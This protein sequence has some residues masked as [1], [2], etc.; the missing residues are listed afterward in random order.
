MVKTA[1]DYEA[2]PCALRYPRGEVVGV[3]L[4]DQ[5]VAIPIGCGE[6]VGADAGELDVLFLGAGLAVQSALHARQIVRTQ[7]WRTGLINAR[8][9]KP[10]DTR[11]LARWVGASRLIVTVEE[12][13]VD[14]GF[15]TAV[16]EWM[17]EAGLYREVIRL[18]VPDRFV[19][20]AA[21][22]AQR[23]QCGLDGAGIAR[24]ALERLGDRA[25]SRRGSG[26]KRK[27]GDHS[28]VNPV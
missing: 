4:D 14:G 2:G 25:L 7:G 3:P 15:G 5:P 6:L 16:L 28:E 1:I 8:F 23:A 19:E 22:A 12:N 26:A 10:L 11:L 24:A 27:R 9:I 20:H 18:G 21:P 13:T 17:Q